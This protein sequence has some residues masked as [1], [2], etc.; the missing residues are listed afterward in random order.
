MFWY[1]PT[2]E[3][4]TDDKFSFIICNWGNL[5]NSDK[6]RDIFGT[7]IVISHL[8]ISQKSTV[9]EINISCPDEAWVPKGISSEDLSIALALDP[10]EWTIWR[11][12]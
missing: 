6:L 10:A 3:D 4:G 2:Q 7:N 5:K 11:I 1:E 8:T 12:L 9:F